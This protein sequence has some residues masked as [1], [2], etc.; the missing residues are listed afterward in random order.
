MFG[1]KHYVPILKGKM[2]E[3]RALSHLSTGTK[4][5][6]TPFLDIP[7]SENESESDFDDHLDKK[8]EYIRRFWGK[9]HLFVD[10]F[11]IDLKR[12]T[13]SGR[14]F[15][16]FFFDGLRAHNIQAIPVTALDRDDN[17]NTSIA[18]T[19]D[20]DKRGVA[21]RLQR[22]DIEDP[23]ST[24]Q[25][26]DELLV[27]L[28]TRK[29]DVH[30][31]LDL[32]EISQGGL[33]QDVTD[34]ID[35]LIKSPDLNAWKTLV[36]SASGFPP[37]MGG[38]KKNSYELIPRTELTL[39]ERVL[40]E[41][42]AKKL[43]RLPAF[44][45]Y[46]VCHP[47]LLDFDPTMNPSANIRYTLFRDW[48]IVKG[49]G[50]KQ[51]VN[52][53]KTYNYSQFYTLAHSLRLNKSYYGKAFSYGDLYVYNC[54]VGSQGPGNLPKWREVGTNHHLTLVAQQIANRPAI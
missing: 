44:S 29:N 23:K 48:L 22:H 31:F 50:L 46:G 6:L 19:I 7:R 4:V 13:S 27:D 5:N 28:Q 18:Q 30:L 17:Y 26:L 38:V 1:Y 36:L 51:R 11:D 24:N 9:D 41:S 2:G 21:V 12:R 52:G 37:H 45:D 47:N 33:S 42:K 16:R 49:G 53:R 35:F 32:R 10:F 54:K 43:N 14:H 15:V 40:A 34:V 20:M 8:I 39:W 3:F 25:A